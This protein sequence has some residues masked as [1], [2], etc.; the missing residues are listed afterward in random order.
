MLKRYN[1]LIRYHIISMKILELLVDVK[2][3]GLKKEDPNELA[4]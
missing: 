2:F 1:S 3:V 4:K